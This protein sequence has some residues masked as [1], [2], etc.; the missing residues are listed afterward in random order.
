M[1]ELKFFRKFSG[2]ARYI[3]PFLLTIAVLLFG[4]TPIRIPG[5]SHITPMYGIV[6]IFYWS[7]YRPDLV[8]YGFGFTIGIFEDLL[9]GSHIGV[10][11]MPILITQW[12]V[13]NQQKYFPDD[14][15]ITS[16]FAFFFVAFG[17]GLIKWLCFG[18]ITDGGF[19]PI[20]NLI[21]ACLLTAIIFPII[22]WIF[23]KFQT[24]IEI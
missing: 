13:F 15:F 1:S 5:F 20:L 7:I 6:I 9:H 3:L 4:V 10:S 2:R 11:V 16:W 12:I 22:S 23:S 14:S 24:R 19:M 17:A 18:F 21:V 8:G